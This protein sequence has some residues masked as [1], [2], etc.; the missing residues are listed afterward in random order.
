L[1]SPLAS[2]RNINRIESFKMEERKMLKGVT[3]D[4]GPTELPE[5][6]QQLRGVL[7]RWVGEPFAKAAVISVYNRERNETTEI[8]VSFERKTVGV[9]QGIN[10]D[11]DKPIPSDC[12]IIFNDINTVL[13]HEWGE[14]TGI[15][16]QKKD[17]GLMRIFSNGTIRVEI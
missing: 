2:G 16:L 6:H 14:E 11:L 8:R 9:F 12:E 15:K 3:R 17:G 1:T 13:Y 10:M 4:F 7:K 5:I